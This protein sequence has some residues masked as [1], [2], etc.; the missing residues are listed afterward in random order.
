MA[1]TVAQCPVPHDGITAAEV[2]LPCPAADQAAAV[3]VLLVTSPSRNNQSAMI[4]YA[5]HLTKPAEIRAQVHVKFGLD[6]DAKWHLATDDGR[7]VLSLDT[8]SLARFKSLVLVDGEPTTRPL[9]SPPAIPVFGHAHLLAP[10]FI[11]P[12]RKLTA[13]LGPTFALTIFGRRIVVTSDADV[14]EQVMYES[15]FFT[16]KIAGLLGEI[17]PVGGRGLFTSDTSDPLWAKAH[18]LLIPGFGTAPL[19]QYV[20]EMNHVTQQLTAAIDQQ[21]GEPVMVTEWMTRFTF[22]TIGM[23][24]FA[25]DFHLLD[26]PDAP[27]HPFIDAMNY[28]LAEAKVRS[29][30]TRLYKW[31][32][33]RTNRKFDASLA[34][35]RQTVEEVI[36]HRRANP[37]ATKRDMLNFMLTSKDENGESL[38][39]ENIRDQVI[40]FLIA[41]HETT[42]TLLSWCLYFL[43][44]YPTVRE[45]VLE[46]AVRVCGTDPTAEITPQQISQLTYITQVLKETLRVRPPVPALGKSCVTSTVL[47]GG[48]LVEAGNGV[49]VNINGLHHS[50]D[51][52]GP[53]PTAFNPDHFSKE[54]E[55]KR[56]RFAWLPFSTAERACL[57][58]AFAMLEAK[59]A[60]ATL[61]RKYE[62]EYPR[63][64]PCTFD[65]V[66]VTLK[67]LDLH[68]LFHARIELPNP[69]ELAARVHNRPATALGARPTTELVAPTAPLPIPGIQLVYG[70]NMGTAEDF[71]H[72]L[73]ESAQRFGIKADMVTLDSWVAQHDHSIKMDWVHVFITSTYNGQPPDNAV[74]AAQWLKGAHDLK[75][76]QYAVFGC[77][78]SQWRTFQ[79]FPKFVDERL[80]ALGAERIANFG[81][82]DADG[83]IEGDFA[84]YQAVFWV[85][86]QSHFNL[87]A[88]DKQSAPHPMFTPVPA[89]Q[90]ESVQVEYVDVPAAPLRPTAAHSAM[91]LVANRELLTPVAIPGLDAA[92]AKSTRH[93]EIALPA[94]SETKYREGDHFEVW[95]EQSPEDVAAVA[96]HVGADLDAVF[97]LKAQQGSSVSAKTAAGAIMAAGTA[98]TVRDALTFFA[99]LTGAPTRAIA[100]LVLTKLGQTEA[101]ER[102]RLQDRDALKAFAAI[103]RRT[104]D[105]ILAAPGVTLAEVLAATAATI[106]RRYSIASA[107]ESHPTTVHL[108]VGVVSDGVCS[109]FLQRAEVGHVLY[110]AVKPCRDA[111]HLPDDATVPL[112]MVGAGT[113]LAP[114]LGFVAARRA[115]GAAAGDAHLFYGCRHPMH[116]D[117]YQ[118]ELTAAVDEGILTGLHVAYSRDPGSKAKYVQHAIEQAAETVVPQLL[119]KGA[120]LFVCGSARG[121]AK[122][123]FK[124]LASM[125]APHVPDQDGE[126]YLTGL[127]QAGRYVEDVW[128]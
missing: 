125:V 86:L 25:F 34:L 38:D 73:V 106:P 115:R 28:C 112:I 84:A 104:L 29:S 33:S 123:V 97:S 18:K 99:D 122:D 91:T 44:Q 116:D 128:G 103:Y 5:K 12:I 69:D 32:P 26:A 90:A 78:N 24:G 77:G 110:G 79:Q 52:W 21:L 22:Q 66:A 58:M 47:P 107:F 75:G 16:K 4:H 108:C 57:G 20:P 98:A 43:T 14:V 31:V 94:G 37:D 2:D 23:C 102:V 54:N 117:L 11:T 80:D 71:C 83:D 7:A 1:P 42:S 119:E 15:P 41:G 13:E 109:R 101:T 96:A 127:Q 72:Q 56:H 10:E 92:A 53:N 62:F 114:F 124:T 30:H 120:R 50:R 88:D 85:S 68:M 82:G 65:P 100:E 121:M 81:F 126:K 63:A 113:G 27:M 51:L 87:G 111:F 39:D 35:M 9:Q 74:H 89:Q 46:E 3:G 8:V 55:A 6:D 19:K 95:P 60:L 49:M 45:R 93:I 67:P 17:Q 59:V 48:T 76:L 64:E 40:T 70:S 36:T 105:A 61:I 118:A